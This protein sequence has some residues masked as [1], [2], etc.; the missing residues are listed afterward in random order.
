MAVLHRLLRMLSARLLDLR[1]PPR[2]TPAGRVLQALESGAVAGNYGDDAQRM[3]KQA[4][5]IQSEQAKTAISSLAGQPLTTETPAIATND[6]VNNLRT[7]YSD[8]RKT[9]SENYKA[10]PKDTQIAADYVRQGIIPS[11]KDWAKE[12]G[13]VSLNAPELSNARRLYN[14]ANDFAKNDN[15]TAANLYSME[16]WRGAVSKGIRDTKRLQKKH[17]YPVCCSVM[18]RQ[19]MFCHARPSRMAMKKR[20]NC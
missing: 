10:I 11:L 5:E 8:I 3:A 7:A 20:L 14:M 12:F 16:Q 17:S 19:W 6:L 13:T 18:T 2:A 4:R 9:V 15:I 1:L